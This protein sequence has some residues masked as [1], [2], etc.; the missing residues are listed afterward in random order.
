MCKSPRTTHSR[1]D[2]YVTKA[3]QE[4]GHRIAKQCSSALLKTTQ[5]RRRSAGI[6]RCPLV[7]FAFASSYNSIIGTKL[8]SLACD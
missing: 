4:M 2:D 3:G 6:K 1:R 7:D 5:S 8:R